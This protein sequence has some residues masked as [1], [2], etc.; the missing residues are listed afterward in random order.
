MTREMQHG[1]NDAALA[2]GVKV[3]YFAIFSDSFSSK[4]YDQYVMY[5][6]GDIV[7][8][9]LPDLDE[10]D[11]VIR[12]DSSFPP[13]AKSKLEEILG[14]TKV[15]VINVGGKVDAYRNML[16]DESASFS[17][18]TEHVVT[19]HGCRNIY[20]VA[21]IKGK[22]YTQERIDALRSVLDRHGIEFGD[23]RIV[24]GTLW[25]D[26]GAPSVDYILK[27]CE[28]KGKKYPDA[29]SCANDYSAIGVINT[30]RD[31]NIRVPE[32]IIVT[33]FDGVEAA[34]Q[35][36]PSVT[37]SKQP[38]YKMGYESILTFKK[39]WAGEDVS[40]DVRIKGTLMRNQ[41]CGC[42]AM[43]TSDV[44]DIRQVYLRQMGRMSYLE[45]S[46]T[47]MVLS[48]SNARDHRDCFRE[49]GKNAANDTGFK[50]MLL[51]LAPGWE[52]QR[53]VD[54]SY[55]KQDEDIAIVSGF[56]GDRIIDRE[57]IRKKDLLPKDMLE[58]PN[59]YYIFSIHHLQY[60]MGYLIVNPDL[61]L[62]DQISM[63][64]WL[65]ILG[66]MLENFRI[67]QA[68]NVSVERLENLYNRDMLTGLYNRRG[69]EMFFERYYNE[70]LKDGTALAV[71]VIDMDDL[72]FVNDNYGHAEGDYSLC[73][74]SEAMTSA[75]KNDE[76]C[77][78]TGGDE[79]VVLARD[80][81]EEKAEVY[82]SQMR[83]K[84]AGRVKHDKK[85]FDVEVSVGTCI[86]KL[87]PH[88]TH[89]LTEIAEQF[90]T[91]ADERMYAEKKAHKIKKTQ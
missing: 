83:E 7:A 65:V 37:T 55:A 90:I 71:M 14:K 3:I 74:I 46:T 85:I 34:N 87:N 78:R 11:G 68:L 25:H 86:R 75:A 26:C 77:L 67:R 69:Y 17:E 88:S 66:A 57:V 76:I 63:K 39:L 10:F 42:A 60:Y 8:F 62:I 12:I 36:Y 32:D 22:Y 15:P 27:E 49:I 31:R 24:Y 18:I 61:E 9:E 28:K 54:D 6:E 4:Y 70:C 53:V 58:D 13:F 64:S 82:I 16:N 1:I 35:G 40:Q 84:I 47:N 73:M 44:E 21:G 79:F 5:D 52:T 50:D 81:S 51:C 48:I 43:D 29:I 23:E 2:G 38:F 19:E 59:P 45:Q 30:L 91:T 20:H 72:K 89:T 56:R 41:S 33:G 80:Y